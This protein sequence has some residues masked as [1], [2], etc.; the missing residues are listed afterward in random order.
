M[1]Q[2]HKWVVIWYLHSYVDLPQCTCTQ[3]L[4][5]RGINLSLK[6]WPGVKSGTSKWSKAAGATQR[7]EPSACVPAT[8]PRSWA[9]PEAWVSRQWNLCS[10]LGLNPDA[11][12]TDTSSARKQTAFDFTDSPGNPR[13]SVKGAG[14]RVKIW[15]GRNPG[16][17]KQETRTCH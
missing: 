4:S 7:H 17:V 13:L 15:S 1:H 9:G 5:T 8:L 16:L 3:L 10:V 6:T 12:L 14:M 11:T 2:G